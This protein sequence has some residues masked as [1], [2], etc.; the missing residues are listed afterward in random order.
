MA[1]DHSN[2]VMYVVNALHDL[3]E[4]DLE[5]GEI[6]LDSGRPIYGELPVPM[7]S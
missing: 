6:D 5:T 2:D 4:V 1:Y 3:Y 7:V